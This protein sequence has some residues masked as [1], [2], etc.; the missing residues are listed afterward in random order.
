MGWIKVVISSVVMPTLKVL[1][2]F[3]VD[4]VIDE[5]KELWSDG[6]IQ[7]MAKSAVVVAQSTFKDS[8][9]KKKL[10]MSKLETMLKSSGKKVSEKVRSELIEKAV[11]RYFKK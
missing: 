6:D 3:I 8:D 9:E 4:S 5:V 10:A 11:E 7:L 2:G 1:C